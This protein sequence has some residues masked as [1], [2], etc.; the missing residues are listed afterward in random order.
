MGRDADRSGNIR[1]LGGPEGFDKWIV[2]TFVINPSE[3][4]GSHNTSNKPIIKYMPIQ[5]VYL[6]EFIMSSADGISYIESH[7]NFTV[8]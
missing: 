4:Y 5:K 2:S 3:A 1:S 7:Y 8:E 6:R